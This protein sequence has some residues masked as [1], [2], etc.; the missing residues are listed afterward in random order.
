LSDDLT[1]KLC[2]KSKRGLKNTKLK[3]AFTKDAM[4]F[5]GVREI[6]TFVAKGGQVKDLYIGKIGIKD[7]PLMKNVKGLVDPKFLL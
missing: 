4:Y 1:W 3:T 6:E 5:T 2:V 7:L